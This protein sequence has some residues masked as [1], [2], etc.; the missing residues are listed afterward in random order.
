[1]L[2][3]IIACEVF[4]REI[5]FCVA[6]S[7]HVI[8]LEF[9]PK[10]AH[11][12][13]YMLREMVQE[14]IQ[15]TAD[16]G[17]EY[18]AIALCLGI[19]GNAT[20]GLTSPGI[21]LIL[22]RAHD[23]CT[24]FLGSKE[25]FKEYFEDRPS[26]PFS[27]AGYIEHGGDYVRQAGSTKG[28]NS[29]DQSYDEYV[30]QYGEENAKYLWESLHPGELSQDQHQ[31][32]F[33]EIPELDDSAHAEACRKKAE[34]EEKEFVKLEGSI[35]LIRKLVFGEWDDKDFLTVPEGCRIAGVYDLDAVIKTV[36]GDS[37]VA[38]N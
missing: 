13:P 25:R 28:F 33:I 1:M 27:S 24:L 36:K 19:C 7:P 2:I 31:V 8:D 20:I 4:T 23:C 3:K 38:G 21:P 9:T 35:E 16:S 37:E 18:D 14:R 5:C 26:T 17:R 30:E 34:A 22:P 10:G 32:V 12:E 29:F 6:K 11:D 15:A